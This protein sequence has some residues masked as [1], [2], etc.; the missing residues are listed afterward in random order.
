MEACEN[1]EWEIKASYG[2]SERESELVVKLLAHY[3]K[4]DYV[5]ADRNN[6]HDMGMKSEVVVTINW[7]EG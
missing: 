7:R 1:R 3:R 2:T 5:V 4:R 6:A